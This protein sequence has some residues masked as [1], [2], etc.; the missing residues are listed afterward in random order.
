[1]AIPS[2]PDPVGASGGMRRPTM[3]D[4][5]ALS[6]VSMKTVSR[7][8]NGEPRVSDEVRSRVNLAVERLSYRPD[9]RA[10]SLR[11]DGQRS[12]TIGLAVSSVSNPFAA[13]V[14]RAIENAAV[15][16]H[17]AVIA[18]S[19]D[20][21]PDQERPV[22]ETL[23]RRR[24]DG[25]IVIPVARNQAY[26]HSELQFGT[27]AVFIDRTPV[28]I[29][30]DAVVSDHAS[31]AAAATRH[32][33]QHGHRRIAF[34]GDLTSMQ[35]TNE[36][37]RG[38]RRELAV[39][40]IPAA[41][42]TVITEAHDA[43]IA[44]RLAVEILTGS[45]PPTAIFSGQNLITVGVIRALRELSLQRSVA[46]IGFDD[47]PLADLLEPGISVVAQDPARIG[48]LA[49]SRLFDRL[50]GRHDAPATDVIPTRLIAR[51][52]GEIRPAE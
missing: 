37:V 42:A 3:R 40:G 39:A 7:V 11:R 25:L 41:E 29:D 26:L 44:E 27:P 10:G 28:G 31:G 51:G 14:H 50:D 35:S 48:R 8:I 38:F 6:G 43:E 23:L 30:A 9:P 1:M 45:E 13:E 32:L 24:V 18:S 16:R 17:V 47:I 12:D 20:D 22:V 34:L 21:Q 15:E 19:T 4:V 46:L 5:A 2:E 52:S 49:A 36:R 33:I